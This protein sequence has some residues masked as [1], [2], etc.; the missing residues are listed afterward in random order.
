M[1]HGRSISRRQFIKNASA[2][3]LATPLLT[4]IILSGRERAPRATGQTA[5][6]GSGKSRVI[7]VRDLNVLDENGRPR[8]EVVQ[9]MLDSGIYLAPSAFEAMF[10]SL[11]H[12]QKDVEK[13][14]A[15]ARYSFIESKK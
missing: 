1:K 14:I 2:A 6:V 8:P 3:A 11:A 10:V 5:A 13:T 4:P 9:A 15:T 12:T 7:L